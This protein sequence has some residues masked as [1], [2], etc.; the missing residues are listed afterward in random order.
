[1]ILITDR[2]NFLLVFVIALDMMC[3][4]LN[5]DTI[6]N[7]GIR[8]LNLFLWRPENS[9]SM[10]IAELLATDKTKTMIQCFFQTKSWNWTFLANPDIDMNYTRC[11]CQTRLTMDM[12]L[13]ICKA[14]SKPLRGES[15]L[16]PNNQHQTDEGTQRGD[17][18]TV[19]NPTTTPQ[20]SVCFRF[21]LDMFHYL[22]CFW[23]ITPCKS[24]ALWQLVKPSKSLWIQN[25][26]IYCHIYVVHVF[27]FDY[28]EAWKSTYARSARVERQSCGV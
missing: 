5:D 8:C 1:M 15:G 25:N 13:W 24:L 14:Q 4:F 20:L 17:T 28:L 3:L 19:K 9:E 6:W 26:M 21:G 18:L 22:G 12:T 27:L 11:H 2:N 16:G 23:R 10:K 7:C